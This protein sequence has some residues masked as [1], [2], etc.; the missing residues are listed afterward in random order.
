MAAVPLYFNAIDVGGGPA[1]GA[2]LNVYTRGTSTRRPMWSDVGLTTPLTNP[3]VADADGRFDGIYFDSAVQYSILCTTADGATTILEADIVGGALFVSTSPVTLVIDASWLPMLSADQKES[4]PVPF[5]RFG[6]IQ[7]LIDYCAPLAK[8]GFIPSGNYTASGLTHTSGWLKFQGDGTGSRLASTTNAPILTLSEL[9]HVHDL[10][11]IGSSEVGKTDQIG[12]LIDD[13]NQVRLSNLTLANSYT[14]LKTTG[15]VFY[16]SV[17]NTKFFDGPGPT[18]VLDGSSDAGMAM[19]FLNC[20]IFPSA[21]AGSVFDISN[22]GSIIMTGGVISPALKA[23]HSLH[24][25]STSTLAGISQYNS[26]VWEGSVKSAIRMDGTSPLPILHQYFANN[27]ANQS[28]AYPTIL[29]KYGTDIQ[30]TGG[31]LSG[32]S[33]ALEIVAAGIARDINLTGVRMELNTSDP[34]VKIGAGAKV[35]KLTLANVSLPGSNKLLDASAA[36]ASDL[37]HIYIDGGSQVGSN[38]APV[39]MPSGGYAPEILN[40]QHGNTCKATKSGTNQTGIETGVDTVVTFGTQIWDRGIYDP[41]TES[42]RGIYD[43][44]TSEITPL[45][46]PTSFDVKGYVT[47]VT[48]GGQV[49]FQLWKNGSKI[50]NGPFFTGSATNDTCLAARF[51]DVAIP[52][53]VYQI[54]IVGVT[55]GTITINGGETFTSLTVSQI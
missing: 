43:P 36:T 45:P 31:I 35:Y 19:Q 44:A 48:A 28:G 29:L 18:I 54:R 2:L 9:A 55:A 52:G 50:D 33:S 1:S 38:V 26:M 16:S 22:I 39:S 47:G 46:G 34:A 30:Y 20:E 40:W 17:E 13:T 14:Q 3:I 7:D 41:T 42:N 27:Y 5:G 21:A 23:E 24:I 4:G 15:T 37:R 53:D 11:F 32:V 49:W 8:T 25:R 12:I 51:F 6:D 10:G